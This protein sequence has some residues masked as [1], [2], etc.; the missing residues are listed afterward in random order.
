VN[1]IQGTI[2]RTNNFTD[3]Y[4]AFRSVD[5]NDASEAGSLVALQTEF[6]DLDHSRNEMVAAVYRGIL[7][8]HTNASSGISP[9]CQTG[10]CTFP[11]STVSGAYHSLGICAKVEDISKHLYKKQKHFGLLEL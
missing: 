2:P 8:P 5:T 4:F 11:D 7:T 1:G 9:Y 10:N 3:G 6:E